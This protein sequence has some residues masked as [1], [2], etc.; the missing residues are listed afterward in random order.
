MNKKLICIE[1]P[2]GCLLDVDIENCRVITVKGNDCPKGN[3]YAVSETENPERVLTSTVKAKGLDLKMLPVR[4]DKPIPK[5]RILEAMETIKMISVD[6]PVKAGDVI[7]GDF[8]GLGVK[9]IATRNAQ[10][11]D[12]VM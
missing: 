7:S 8:M 10:A 2:K 3:I 11:A 4:T 12:N 1:C 9:L 5:G 6:T